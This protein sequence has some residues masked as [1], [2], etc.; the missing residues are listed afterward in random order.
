MHSVYIFLHKI[1]LEIH[2]LYVSD[3]SIQFF[4]GNKNEVRVER[5][6][7]LQYCNEKEEEEEE[8]EALANLLENVIFD[9]EDI[10]TH[11]K[12]KEKSLLK[13]HKDKKTPLPNLPELVIYN[14]IVRIPAEYLQKYRYLCKSW[15]DII[16]SKMFIAQN[17]IHGK[18]ELLILVK[19]RSYFKATSLRMDEK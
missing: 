8:E 5:E 3:C 1:A 14:I 13:Y 17:F 15:H 11:Y 9:S 12:T 6:H 2:P 10:Y 19:K 18:A 4:T 16:S 7:I